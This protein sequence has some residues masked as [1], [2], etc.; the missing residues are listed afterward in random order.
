MSK[1]FADD[2]IVT[3]A[4]MDPVEWGL[5]AMC[6]MQVCA[7]CE[8]PPEQVEAR[9]NALNPPGTDGVWKIMWGTSTDPGDPLDGPNMAPVKCEN[10]SARMH[11][12]LSC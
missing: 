2:V 11:Y 4:I 9:A 6:V 5:I 10:D 7:Y 1:M 12:L 3:K 8:V